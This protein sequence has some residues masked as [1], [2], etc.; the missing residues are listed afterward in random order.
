MIKKIFSVINIR[1]FKWT[2]CIL[3]YILSNSLHLF[4]YYICDTYKYNFYILECKY[5]IIQ[6][7]LYVYIYIYIADAHRSCLTHVDSIFPI[8][9]NVAVVLVTAPVGVA[10]GS[11]SSCSQLGRKHHRLQTNTAKAMDV[12]RPTPTHRNP[13]QHHRLQNSISNPPTTTPFIFHT[14]GRFDL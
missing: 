7:T 12:T 9:I 2:V 14:I 1:L 4:I 8:P 10:P 6:F 13:N 3:L 5:S 11:H